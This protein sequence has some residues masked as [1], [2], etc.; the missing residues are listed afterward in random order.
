M[1]GEGG[2]AALGEHLCDLLGLLARQAIDDAA[3]PFVRAMKSS[4]WRLVLDLAST[5]S[6]MFGR[7]KPCTIVSTRLPKSC[8]A[9]SARVTSSAVAV[10]AMIGI[11]GNT[12]AS[13]ES[14]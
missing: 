14:A 8:N 10:S 9:M 11:L 4:N 13:F 5:V 2:D 7:S 1:I 12:S 6:A 3:G